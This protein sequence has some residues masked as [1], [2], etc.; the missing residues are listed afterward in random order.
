MQDPV[1]KLEHPAL[2]RL[3]ADVAAGW[4]PARLRLRTTPTSLVHG[5]RTTRVTSASFSK[6]RGGFFEVWLGLKEPAGTLEGTSAFSLQWTDGSVLMADGPFLHDEFGMLRVTLPIWTLV[7]AASAPSLWVTRVFGGAD[8]RS[9]NLTIIGRTVS[10]DNAFFSARYDYALI[11]ARH[12][13]SC[14][15]VI[16]THGTGAPSQQAL[17]RD[18]MAM[19]VALGTRLRLDRL[20]GVR[21]GQTVAYAERRIGDQISRRTHLA[22]AVPLAFA[23][24][25]W[26]APFVSAVTSWD[27]AHPEAQLHVPLVL[28]ADAF[29]DHLEGQYLKFHV[30]LEA[31]SS[32]VAGKASEDER[33]L[34]KSS[35]EYD[36]WLVSQEAS[37]ATVAREGEVDSLKAKVRAARF[38]SS[39]GAV[40]RAL[41]KYGIALMPEERAMFKKEFTGGRNLVVHAAKMSA[42]KDR[43]HQRDIGRIAQLRTLVTALVAR[44]VGYEGAITGWRKTT[45]HVESDRAG[46]LPHDPGW[47]APTA[48]AVEA[49]TTLI[50]A[51]PELGTA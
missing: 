23:G 2:C 49:A 31:F 6:S 16:D 13:R 38:Q 3:L 7:A 41:A 32:V 14:M 37:L 22:G 36:A 17:R 1:K 26:P 25:F 30:A 34:V 42:E 9:G 15:M 4:R 21:N 47:W 39:T 35:A 45:S 44:A 46:W 12:D 19:E 29:D 43:D 10:S 28:Y 11:S 27:A 18:L 20:Y 5:N 51:E 48:S 40:M 8:V 50:L 24:P 33:L